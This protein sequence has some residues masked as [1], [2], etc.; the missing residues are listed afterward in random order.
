MLQLV[1]IHEQ[2]KQLHPTKKEGTRCATELNIETAT[3]TELPCTLQ[4]KSLNKRPKQEGLK[5]IKKRWESKPL[6]GQ[7]PKRS[8]QAEEM[9][10]KHISGYVEWV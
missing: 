1:H 2:S 3:G 10:T 8:K 9:K 5:K 7:Y 6:H 4:A